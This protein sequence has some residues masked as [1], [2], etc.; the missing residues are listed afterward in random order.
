MFRVKTFWRNL[1]FQ[2]QLRLQNFDMSADRCH[3][4]VVTFQQHLYMEYIS[5]LK[6]Y[7]RAC[8]SYDDFFDRRSLLT[9]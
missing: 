4:Y 3:L 8:G 7:S 6:Q 9:R 5:Q 2:H 1:P